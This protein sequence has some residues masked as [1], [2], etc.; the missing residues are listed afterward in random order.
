MGTNADRLLGEET[1]EGRGPVWIGREE[2]RP[3]RR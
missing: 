1:N 2:T 3:T